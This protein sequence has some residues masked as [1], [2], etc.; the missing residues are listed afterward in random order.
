MSSINK[1]KIHIGL[2]QLLHNRRY[3]PWYMNIVAPFLHVLNDFFKRCKLEMI[4]RYILTGACMEKTIIQTESWTSLFLC[5]EK[6][7]TQMS[8]FLVFISPY[9]WHYL[10]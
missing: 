4:R 8:I 2:H 7:M 3:N 6:D 9:F 5:A 1:I 10:V